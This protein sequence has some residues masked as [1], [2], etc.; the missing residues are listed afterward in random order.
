MA[1]TW[2]KSC[3]AKSDSGQLRKIAG[4]PTVIPLSGGGAGRFGPRKAGSIILD[5][6]E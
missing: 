2:M 4:I 5:Q 3:P 1:G 6:R